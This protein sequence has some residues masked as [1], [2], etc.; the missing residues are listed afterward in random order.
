MGIV[1]SHFSSSCETIRIQLQESM[2]LRA[3]GGSGY[4]NYMAKLR[5]GHEAMKSVSAALHKQRTF[6]AAQRAEEA[7]AK[8]HVQFEVDEDVARNGGAAVPLWQQ[9]DA[10]LNTKDA[11]TERFKLRTH[12]LVVKALHTFWEAVRRSVRSGDDLD[13]QLQPTLDFGG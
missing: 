2:T 10:T 9:G 12:P 6:V 11:I 5:H 3:A 8:G 13:Q 4:S 1:L 7:L